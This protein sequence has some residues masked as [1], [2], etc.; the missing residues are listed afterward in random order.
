M[1]HTN[2]VAYCLFVVYWFHTHLRRGNL[3]ECGKTLN[4]PGAPTFNP[5]SSS[6]LYE[7][8]CAE[9]H[10]DDMIGVGPP[11][12]QHASNEARAV[13]TEGNHLGLAQHPAK[14]KHPTLPKAQN[15]EPADER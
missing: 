15:D 14:L 1:G 13:V 11:D 9:Q 7:N 3:I 5:A 8:T 4:V 6:I 12:L 10:M 2:S